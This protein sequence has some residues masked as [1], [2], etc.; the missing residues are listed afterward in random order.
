MKAL[1]FDTGFFRTPGLPHYRSV[2]RKGAPYSKFSKR[3]LTKTYRLFD[4]SFFRTT[5]ITSLSLGD[6]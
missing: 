3:R 1:N 4:V 6:P 5:R 2:I